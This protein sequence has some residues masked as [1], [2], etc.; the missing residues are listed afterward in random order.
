VQELTSGCQACF[1]I[2]S[3]MHVEGVTDLFHGIKGTWDLLEC[4]DCGLVYIDPLIPESVIA[5][6]YPGDYA[7]YV[8]VEGVSHPLA[9]FLKALAILPYTLRFGQPGY[10]PPP[11]GNA[12]MLDIGCGAGLFIREMSSLGWQ[13]TGLDIS[14]QAIE[15]AKRHNPE[16]KFIV[17]FFG[18]IEPDE[19]FDLVTMHHI[20]EH[21]HRPKKV[22]A[23]CYRLL[24]PGGKFV[25]SV[26]NIASWEAKL[27][28][29]RWKG[30]DIPRH[31]VHFK[32]FVLL[33]MLEEAGFEIERKR[34]AMFASSIIESFIMCLP[35]ALRRKLIHS[36]LGRI[37][38]LL[39]LPLAAISYFLG[40]RGVVEII[41]IKN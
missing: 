23:D 18:E 41:A 25:V 16:A 4:T 31:M 30:L 35:A 36:R 2:S 40:N 33:A 26:P 29:R 32:E 17:G 38:Y 13:G 19:R 1:S 27:F 5:D 24:S 7:A 22:I 10:F 8:A 15:I 12:R 6:Y 34:T 11:F 28:G 37:F 3:K 39:L 20:L 9:R 14:A 21:L